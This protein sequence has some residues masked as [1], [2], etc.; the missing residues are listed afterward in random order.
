[1]P[2]SASGTPLP[3]DTPFLY[4]TRHVAAC[5]RADDNVIKQGGY[6]IRHDMTQANANKPD[7]MV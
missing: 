3:F 2:P 4:E 5:H 1:M 7:V 6:S